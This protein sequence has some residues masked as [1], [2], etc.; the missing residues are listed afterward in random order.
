VL[1]ADATATEDEMREFLAPKFS[2]IWLPDG[3]VFVDQIPRTSTGKMLKASLRET[4]RNWRP[5]DRAR[6]GDGSS[7]ALQ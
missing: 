2:K 7:G 4:Y 6:R 3:Y 1:K 5:G